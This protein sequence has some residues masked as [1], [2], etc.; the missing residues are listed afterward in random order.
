LRVIG[1]KTKVVVR[2][3]ETDLP[4]RAAAIPERSSGPLRAVHVSR[5]VPKK[6]LDT[7]LA[8]LQ[9]VSIPLSLDV[10]GPA[11]DEA[12]VDRC[13]QLAESLPEHIT[14]T[15]CGSVGYEEVRATLGAYDVMLFPTKGENFGHI[16]AEAL[17]AAVPVMCTDTTPW[18]SWLRAGG[19]VVVEPDTIS[20]WAQAIEDFAEFTSAQLIDI[21][22]NAATAYAQWKLEGSARP[23][24]FS[25][26]QNRGIGS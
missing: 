24:L 6:G 5:L 13:L 9:D 19:G 11:E 10:F 1:P 22:E 4:P 26:L 16:I 7:V 3:N 20:D 12:F 25:M 18:T 2:E 23:H 15:F 14:V 17:S 8:A 21:R